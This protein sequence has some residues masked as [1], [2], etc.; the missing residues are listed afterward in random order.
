MQNHAQQ[1]AV[2]SQAVGVID[3]AKLLELRHEMADSRSRRADHL[4]QMFLIDSW[5]DGLGSAFLSKMRKQQKDSRQ[6]FLAGIEKLVHEIS[7]KPDVSG[8]QMR[9]E[10]FG[11]VMLL[12]EHASHYRALDPDQCAVGHRGGRGDAQRLPRKAAFTQKIADTEYG[13]YRFLTL[14]GYDRQLDLAFSYVEHGIRTLA[15]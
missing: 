14:L 6:A 13:D 5:E 12:V 2:D 8:K 4:R 7:F 15:L 10:Q 1:A 9:N 3:K 11:D